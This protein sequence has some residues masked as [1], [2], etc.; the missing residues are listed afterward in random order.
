[1]KLSE[2]IYGTNSVEHFILHLKSACKTR[3]TPH[4]KAILQGNRQTCPQVDGSLPIS[5]R[6]DWRGEQTD[7]HRL[8]SLLPMYRMWFELSSAC[9]DNGMSACDMLDR[10][11]TIQLERRGEQTDRHKLQTLPPMYVQAVRV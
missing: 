9:W 11:P 4:M 5:L 10:S 7:R 1:M 2:K 8:I 6:L 3:F